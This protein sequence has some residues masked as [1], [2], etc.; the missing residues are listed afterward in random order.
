VPEGEFNFLGYTFTQFCAA[1]FLI[2]AWLRWSKGIDRGHAADGPGRSRCSP[3]SGP[4]G[5][6]PPIEETEQAARPEPNAQI[7][8]KDSKHGRNGGESPG[9]EVLPGFSLS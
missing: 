2:R 5:L 9:K 1:T 8:T 4:V 7:H 6:A 3:D